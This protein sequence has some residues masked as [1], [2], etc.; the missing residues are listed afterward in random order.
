M[1][2]VG[3]GG[4]LFAISAALLFSP[5]GKDIWWSLL[6]LIPVIFFLGPEYFARL[7]ALFLYDEKEGDNKMTRPCRMRGYDIPMPRLSR[8]VARRSGTCVKKRVGRA[9]GKTWGGKD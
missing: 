1:L 8:P 3:L 2:S 6:G 5:M 9:E 7:C 4:I